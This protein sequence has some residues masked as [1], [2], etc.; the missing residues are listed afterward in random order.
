MNRKLGW[1]AEGAAE[2]VCRFNLLA[3]QVA[4]MGPIRI[5]LAMQRGRRIRHRLSTRWRF[6]RHRGRSVDAAIY[7]AEDAAEYRAVDKILLTVSRCLVGDKA[8]RP[9]KRDDT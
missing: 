8:R 1:R 2:K 5:C 6:R 9:L 4:V 7:S 3:R